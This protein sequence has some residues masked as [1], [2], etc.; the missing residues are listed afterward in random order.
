[1]S[2]ILF[3]AKRKDNGE[4][5]EGSLVYY[6]DI[7]SI[8]VHDER[9]YDSYGELP[10]FKVVP[11]TIGQYTG[12]TDKNGVKIFEGDIVE[13]PDTSYISNISTGE[14][15]YDT[16]FAEIRVLLPEHRGIGV[17][18]LLADIIDEA[19]VIGNVHDNPELLK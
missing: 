5:I 12:L 2:E 9:Y 19:V 11:E 15:Y 14:V 17:T 4:W 7:V 18:N 16:R 1:M 8:I 13:H 10:S 6:R 3:R